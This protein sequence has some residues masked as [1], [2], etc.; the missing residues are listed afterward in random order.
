MSVTGHPDCEVVIVT[1]DEINML[2]I[3][4][5]LSAV[6]EFVFSA[7]PVSIPLG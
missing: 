3:P 6:G 7:S 1:D 4:A 2:M 5:L